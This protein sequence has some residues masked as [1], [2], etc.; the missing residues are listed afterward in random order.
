MEISKQAR[1]VK[2]NPDGSILVSFVMK[3]SNK[4][5]AVM[6]SVSVVDDLSKTFN[7]STGIT[8]YSLETY[9]GLIKNSG[10]DGI[11]NIELVSKS[12]KIASKTTDSLLLKV[13]LESTS[14]VGNYLNTAILS[15]KTKYG[16]VTVTS[17]DPTV[18]ASDST[19]RSP[20][21][22]TIPKVD[23]VIAGG[24]SPNQDGLNDKWIIIRPFGTRVEVQIFNRW[25]NIVYQNAD[26]KNDWTGK[27]ETNFMGEDVPDG[28]YFYI[29]NAIDPT[30]TIKKFA[31]SL[32]IVR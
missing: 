8:V 13:K 26:Y 29:V 25:G 5:D 15:G 19:K 14:I 9:G 23:L 21:P 2:L 10:Y 27:G 31:S 17:N 6:D 24:F 18:N 7:T 3:A 28:T 12:S 20:T 11:A 32:T 4:T 22:F 30:G 16:R 1:E